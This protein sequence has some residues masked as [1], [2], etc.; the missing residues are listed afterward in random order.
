MELASSAVVPLFK[1]TFTT[2]A[3]G[4]VFVAS[5]FI[6]KRKETYYALGVLL[7]FLGGLFLVY[8]FIP[9]DFKYVWLVLGA[10]VHGRVGMSVFYDREWPFAQD[11]MLLYMVAACVVG[12]SAAHLALGE[13]DVANHRVG[14][15]VGW[16]VAAA[17][18]SVLVFS[19]E[20]PAERATVFCVLCVV[21]SSSY[22]MRHWRERAAQAYE[23]LQAQEAQDWNEPIAPIAI[24][25]DFVST[26]EYR[27]IGNQETK[28]ALALLVQ[29][30]R[31]QNWV[32]E[33]HDRI[34]VARPLEPQRPL[35]RHA[36]TIGIVAVASAL[37]INL[38]RRFPGTTPLSS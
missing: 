37:F 9:S 24:K 23:E 18:G 21:Y 3:P 33:N 25:R 17:S 22:F 31:F 8:R 29:D 32:R 36:I 2:I 13:I 6:G 11:A 4:L 19:Q 34:Y 14:D 20:K 1:T 5:A 7:G 26:E 35:W 28:R 38:T 12:L 27:R 10:A 30:P 16:L 15:V